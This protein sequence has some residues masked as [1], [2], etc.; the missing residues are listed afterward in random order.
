MTVNDPG[1][2]AEPR[3]LDPRYEAALVA[4]VVDMLMAMFWAGP[5]GMR[6]AHNIRF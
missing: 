6:R 1:G 5:A 3:A 2:V 4:K